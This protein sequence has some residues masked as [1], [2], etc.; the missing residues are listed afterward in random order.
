MC[1]FDAQCKTMAIRDNDQ[2]D[3]G[4]ALHEPA[5]VPQV[6][7]MLRPAAGEAALDLTIGTGGHALALV[8]AI[9]SAGF[10]VGVDADPDA[11]QIARRRLEADAPCEFQL[12]AGRFSSAARF[13]RAASLSTPTQNSTCATTAAPASPRGRS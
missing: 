5:M 2:A 10:L 7:E 11:L 9:G 1:L 3:A 8:F 6:L 13:A 12:F 4:P